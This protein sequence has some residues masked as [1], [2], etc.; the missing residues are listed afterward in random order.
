MP[1]G[2]GWGEMLDKEIVNINSFVWNIWA[3]YRSCY[4]REQNVM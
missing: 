1:T 4:N 3:A 2:V